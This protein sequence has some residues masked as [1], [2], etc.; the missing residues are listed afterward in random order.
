[1]I[2]TKL[3][4]K[5]FLR[6][7]GFKYYPPK[8]KKKF[9][10]LRNRKKIAKKNLKI[11][12]KKFYLKLSNITLYTN[13]D[14]IW[15][16][17]FHINDREDLSNLHRWSWALKLLSKEKQLNNDLINFI[18]LSFLKWSKKFGSEKVDKTKIYFEPYN[19]SERLSNYVILVKLNI[20]KPNQEIED[21]LIKQFNF[22]IKN[23]EVYNVKL[24][25]HALNNLRAIILFSSYHKARNLENYGL[26]FFI[27]LLKKKIDSNGF[28]K[29]GS[30]N[31]QLIFTRWLLDIYFLSSNPLTK[32]KL[33][34]FVNKALNATCFFSIN[35]KLVTPNFGNISPDFELSW[36]TDFFQKKNNFFLKRYKKK[37]KFS[38]K[39]RNL[40]SNEWFK[41][42]KNSFTIFARNPKFCGF[43]FNHSHNDTFHFVMYYKNN[44]IFIDKGRYDYSL[45][46]LK[47]SLSSH[48]HNSFRIN[49]LPINDD[50][51]QNKLSVKLFLKDIKNINFHIIQNK[52]EKLKMILKENNKYIE[53]VI[54]IVKSKIY[55]SDKIKCNFVIKKFYIFFNLYFNNNYL[56]SKN[57]KTI[58][59]GNN[60]DVQFKYNQ[61][62]SKNEFIEYFSNEYGKREKFLKI[63]L[64]FKNFKNLS[65]Q[66]VISAKK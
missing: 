38:L 22:L 32:K 25:N 13:A 55:I 48:A 28:F 36:L 24:S 4:S 21:S 26:N 61:V 47:E 40:K 12:K 57:R 66:T 54:Q 39:F 29:F 65:F 53:R 64:L 34:K 37:Y 27:Y 44:Q 49:K 58:D 30:S 8:F 46:S 16:S 31:Y 62:F 23:I 7:Y 2:L 43:D 10:L 56:I 50:L 42:Y 51:L 15:E 18:E 33:K 19:I 5:I 3:I 60:L 1:M 11:I 63:C 20:I 45:Q 9:F 41:I 59:I 17:N 52:N 35:K 6:G 14:Q